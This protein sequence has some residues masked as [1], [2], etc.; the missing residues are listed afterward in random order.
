MQENN[1][2]QCDIIR[3][4]IMM[5]ILINLKLEWANE[6]VVDANIIVSALSINYVGS[7]NNFT[8]S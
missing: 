3:Y 5:L 8:A 6:I 1:I 7:Q 4:K 2:T